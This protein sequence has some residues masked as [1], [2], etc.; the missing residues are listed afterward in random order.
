MKL[1]ST[2]DKSLKRVIFYNFSTINATFLYIL[3]VKPT[4]NF[5]K[6][7]VIDCIYNIERQINFW[8]GG[9]IKCIISVSLLSVK[10]CGLL[11]FFEVINS[12]PCISSCF[13]SITVSIVLYT[14]TS[15]Y[16]P[17]RTVHQTQILTWHKFYIIFSFN[18]QRLKTIGDHAI[19]FSPTNKIIFSCYLFPEL[20]IIYTLGLDFTKRNFVIC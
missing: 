3:N 1:S 7:V 13:S 14:P 19:H 16:Y 9:G 17:W 15:P 18:F 10:T 8:R 6:L 11:A 2:L 4:I 12:F 5:S 20:M